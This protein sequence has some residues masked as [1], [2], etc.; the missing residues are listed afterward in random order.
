[1]AEVAKRCARP[2]GHPPWLVKRLP[3]HAETPVHGL[4]EDLGLNTVCRSAKCP[5]LSECWAKSTA[6]FMILGKTC[7]RDCRF[8]AVTHGT[9]APLHPDEPGRV[10]EAAQRLG[11]KYVVVT[12]V[13]RD[14]LPDGGAAQFVAAVRAVHETGAKCEVLVPDFGGNPTSV[15][16]VA[17]AGPEVFGH[18]VETVPRR[19]ETVRPGAAY[20]RSLRVL[21]EAAKRARGG[22]A[23]KSGL[24]LGLGERPEEVERVMRDLVSAG[25][26][27]LTLGQYLS[28]DSTRLPV[29]E[30]IAPE[31]FDEYAARAREHGF[32]AVAAGPFVRSSYEAAELWQA[33]RE[34]IEEDTQNG[35]P[36]A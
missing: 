30:Y 10:A 25:V 2:H 16:T 31:R 6:T 19:Y 29:A 15:R 12:S 22:S 1:M 34:K 28:P 9:P 20:E 35:C 32:A 5:N 8:C 13:T 7:T 36:S 24:M 4:L 23:V 14:D 18:N 27:I 11:L 3:T 26:R 21:E 33:A 17:G